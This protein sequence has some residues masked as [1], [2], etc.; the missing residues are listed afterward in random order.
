M[1]ENLYVIPFLFKIGTFCLEDALKAVAYLLGN[2]GADFLNIGIALQ[3]TTAY[4]QWNIGTIYD[5]M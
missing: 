1:D 2:V 4:V 5:A 3:I